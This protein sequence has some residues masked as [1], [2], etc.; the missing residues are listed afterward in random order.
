MNA[1]YAPVDVVVAGGGIGGLAT[2]YALAR[3]GH[4]VRVLERSPEFAEV[5]A[6]LQMAP[7]ATRILKEWGLLPEVLDAGVT[8]RRLLFKDALDGT[9]LTHLDLDDAFETRFGAPYVVIHRGDLLD[10]LARACVRAGVELVPDCAV[11]DAVPGADGA[12][13]HSSLGEHAAGLVVVADGL[14]SRLRARFSDDEPICSGYVAYRGAFPV[15]ELDRDLDAET[16]Q[17]VVVHLGPG[18]HLVRYPLRR[19]EI[20][21]TVAV[22]RSPSYEPGAED[23]G[24]PEELDAAFAGCDPAVR[25]SLKSL[26]RD[27]RWPMYDRRPISRW[28]D[29]RLVLTGDAAHPMLQYLAQ[30][31]CQAIEDAYCLAAELGAQ[32]DLAGALKSYEAERTVR[33]ARVQDTARIW[34]DM[35]HVDGVG[36]LLRNELFRV[37]D[38]RDYT[39]V[40]WL[41]A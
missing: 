10:I 33:T 22:F 27:R 15:A 12:V 20:L 3:A 17:N 40:D 28:T 29:G 7:N 11:L 37:R 19:G 23:W 6:G 41:Y 35:W 13:V 21:N 31:A 34:G 5:G 32:P 25:G 14:R 8:P 18:C 38:P 1:P 9:D 2:A 39:Y 16:A 24:G 4:A 36:R 30:G 26:W